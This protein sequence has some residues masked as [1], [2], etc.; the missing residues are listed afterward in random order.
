MAMR[1]KIIPVKGQEVFDFYEGMPKDERAVMEQGFRCYWGDIGVRYKLIFG[2]FDALDDQEV[3]RLQNARSNWGS[4]LGAVLSNYAFVRYYGRNPE[5]SQD[6]RLE[7]LN[8][9]RTPINRPCVRGGYYWE[10]GNIAEI[11]RQSK[12]LVCYVSGE[13]PKDLQEKVLEELTT[14]KIPFYVLQ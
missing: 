11:V 5:Q 4:L 13:M 12:A 9:I 8:H 1:K 3:A 6:D 2:A 10:P 14:T 7:V